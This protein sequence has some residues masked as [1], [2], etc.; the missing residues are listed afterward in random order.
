MLFASTSV[1]GFNCTTPAISSSRTPASRPRARSS[2]DHLVG[3]VEAPAIRVTGF[4]AVALKGATHAPH[5]I[6]CC[7]GPQSTNAHSR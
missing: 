3:A 7:R 5:E 2:F 6:R 4:T 1:V